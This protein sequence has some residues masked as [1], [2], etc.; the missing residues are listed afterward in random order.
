MPPSRPSKRATRLM[1][2]VSPSTL[3]QGNQTLY[4]GPMS[5]LLKWVFHWSAE[6]TNFFS[7]R[8][9]AGSWQSASKA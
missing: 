7:G 2:R 4:E 5:E 1:L 8:W 3:S 9:L 6:K